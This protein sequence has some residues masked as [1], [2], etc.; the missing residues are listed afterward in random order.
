M[1]EVQFVAAGDQ[2]TVFAN[3]T[4]KN[5]I[6]LSSLLVK[7]RDRILARHRTHTQ[8]RGAY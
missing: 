7:L 2:L 6:R 8:T 4:Y 1:G 5:G 3:V